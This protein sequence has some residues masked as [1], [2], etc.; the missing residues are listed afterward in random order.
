MPVTVGNYQ[1]LMVVEDSS[2]PPNKLA[3]SYTVA[4]HDHIRVG[5]EQYTPLIVSKTNGFDFGRTGG[6]DPITVTSTIETPLPAGLSVSSTAV[7]L[8]GVATATGSSRMSVNAADVTGDAV[9]RSTQVV[10]CPDYAGPN[11]P[12]TL[13]EGDAA[14]G[15]PVDA[16]KGSTI[17]A[18]VKTGKKQAKRVLDFVV[19][20]ARGA[21]VSGGKVTTG[22]L[23][24]AGVKKLVAPESGR[25]FVL[26]TSTEGPATELVATVTAVAPKSQSET[27]EDFGDPGFVEIRFGALQGGRFT[28]RAKPA[29]G[30]KLEGAT[31]QWLL[32]PDG[33]YLTANQLTITEKG[34]SV[35]V[36][37]DCDVSG[38]WTLRLKPKAG[39]S[40]DFGYALKI[41]QPRDV[42]YKVD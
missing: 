40:G 24:R 25:F 33:R 26:C 15:W 6:T 14:C 23:G 35:T 29:R 20:D 8:D 9:A 18:V 10:V 28:V 34:T 11:T 13:A 36:E 39:P 19:V 16:V 3:R 37:G 7:R 4:I 2:E 17:T 31:V 38:T 41:A 30:S 32:S 22:K 42:V 1:F 21:V 12:A 5:V 27:F